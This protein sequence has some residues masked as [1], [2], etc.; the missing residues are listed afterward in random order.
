MITCDHA[1]TPVHACRSRRNGM[2]EKPLVWQ[3]VLAVFLLLGMLPA[4][5]FAWGGD[6]PA[7]YRP[8]GALAFWCLLALFVWLV[9]WGFLRSRRADIHADVLARLFPEGTI[10]QIGP[11]HLWLNVLVLGPRVRAI[12]VVQ[13]TR[14]GDGELRLVLRPER[15]RAFRLASGGGVFAEDVPP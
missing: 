7:E 5:I 6:I 10:M 8:R 12:A 14:N 3:H 11:M 15:S 1:I 4:A 9:V 2:G 13:N